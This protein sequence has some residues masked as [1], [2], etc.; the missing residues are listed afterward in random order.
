MNRVITIGSS[1]SSMVAGQLNL[2]IIKHIELTDRQEESDYFA[3][4][5][6]LDTDFILIDL[7]RC[8]ANDIHNFNLELWRNRLKFLH[9][10]VDKYRL[11][12]PALLELDLE[13]MDQLLSH[14]DLELYE[15]L[16]SGLNEIYSLYKSIFINDSHRISGRIRMPVREISYL[17]VDIY[18][19]NSSI[20][21]PKYF[22]I[23]CCGNP[24]ISHAL[25]SGTH[26]VSFGSG[27][28][29][30]LSTN[31]FDQITDSYLVVFNGNY[32]E[33]N[34]KN[35][36]PFFFGRGIAR[37][38]G[39]ASISFADPSLDYSAD[40]SIGWYAGNSFV[41]TYQFNVSRI[42]DYIAN[43]SQAIPILVGGSGGGFAALVMSAITQ[44]RTKAFV[45]NSLTS[46]SNSQS[47]FIEPFQSTVLR[48]GLS[49]QVGRNA[50]VFQAS[51][52]TA[53]I[54]N[55]IRLSDISAR[56]EIVY[57]QNRSDL[58]YHT[59]GLY[60]FLEPI[61][62]LQFDE[63]HQIV[64]SIDGNVVAWVG[65][66]G[67][68]HVPPRRD[69]IINSIKNLS[70]GASPHECIRGLS[71]Q[72]VIEMRLGERAILHESSSLELSIDSTESVLH[73][74]A[75]VVD[76]LCSEYVNLEFAFY[77]LKGG[78]V[79]ESIMYVRENEVTFNVTAYKDMVIR[80]FAKDYSGKI[81]NKF[82]NVSE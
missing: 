18:L 44:V 59:N 34:T 75:F 82:F 17:N 27:N 35:T 19:N 61:A 41:P 11:I 79:V 77:L 64:S 66:W 8:V 38:A 12:S 24:G 60:Q 43:L 50:N 80:A 6:Y 47:M 14:I 3:D 72:T 78:K 1:V 5:L 52:D 20:A 70:E 49:R 33:R 73:V 26:R 7:V 2:N 22:G 53:G 29:I 28:S 42:I 58:R 45:W 74:S 54:V 37:E 56:S 69:F 9:S 23:T 68:G 65:E 36:G 13:P 30:V 76:D 39:I 62:A 31:G 15:K 32:T 10:L 81:I 63:A 55:S 25:N 71:D 67:T 40:I 16:N 57:V 46:L 4:L 48:T 51:L 21:F